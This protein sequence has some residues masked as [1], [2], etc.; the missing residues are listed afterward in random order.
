M[1]QFSFEELIDHTLC[2][3]G[4]D[5]DE[6]EVIVPDDFGGV[7]VTMLGDGVFKGHPEI[8]SV[9]IPDAVIF[10]GGFVF[11]GC[12]NLRQITLPSQLKDIFQY[13]FVRCGLEEIALPEHVNS[14][15]P[16]AFKDCKQLRRVI[17]N[18]G[19]QKI[20]AWAFQGCDA[21]T[22]LQYAANTEVSE[23]AQS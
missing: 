9:R 4:Y 15:P 22:D 14:I 21:L 3:T 18:P 7:P 6:L 8:T 11:D 10:M 1:Q 2:I 16:F 19:L 13:T 5:G 20:H 17:C 12:V 23:H